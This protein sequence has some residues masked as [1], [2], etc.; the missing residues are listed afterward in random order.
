[1][2][3]A[4]SEFQRLEVEA[5]AILS[6]V[7]IHDVTAIDLPGGGA[8][9]TLSDVRLLLGPGKLTA[10]NPVVRGLFSLR[11]GLGRLFGWD[12]ERR[13][14]RERS[15][16]RRIGSGIERRSARPPGSPDGPFRLLYLLERESLAEV[17]NATVHAFLASALTETLGG[18]RLYWAVYVKPVSRLTPV[19]MA[20]IE[21][22]R[23]FVVYP[24]M[25]RH[26]RKAWVRRYRPDAAAPGPRE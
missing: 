16:V 26:L 2:R 7:K 5:H 17:Q 23:R 3:V 21:P 19:Y 4:A 13:V 11:W 12:R 15:Y 8:G 20:F 10:P 6:D 9:R 24:M 14:H 25:L 22:F 18:Y 1:M